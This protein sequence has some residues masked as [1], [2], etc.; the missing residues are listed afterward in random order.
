VRDGKLTGER[1]N[2][3]LSFWKKMESAITAS[4][5]H[6]VNRNFILYYKCI[7]ILLILT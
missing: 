2:K 5:L 6:I 3:L 4:N 7:T 1:K